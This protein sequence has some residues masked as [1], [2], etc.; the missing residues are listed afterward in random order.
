MREG[1]MEKP[2]RDREA[3]REWIHKERKKMWRFV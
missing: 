2:E 3:N 1:K